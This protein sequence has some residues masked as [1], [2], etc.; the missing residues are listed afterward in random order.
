MLSTLLVTL[1]IFFLGSEALAWT[2]YK[3]AGTK[4]LAT[5]QAS[6][7]S[8]DIPFSQSLDN[9]NEFYRVVNILTDKDPKNNTEIFVQDLSE[10]ENAAAKTCLDLK[11][12]TLKIRPWKNQNN[13]NIGAS[14]LTGARVQPNNG[15]FRLSRLVVDCK[16][17]KGSRVFYAIQMSL[18]F[19][20]SCVEFS[21][22]KLVNLHFRKKE[23]QI[24]E[25][26][27]SKAKI[28]ARQDID[29]QTLAMRIH[30]LV[31]L[32]TIRQAG[33][34]WYASNQYKKIAQKISAQRR[35]KN[36][37]AFEKLRSLEWSEELGQLKQNYQKQASKFPGSYP[38][39]EIR[40][41]QAKNILSRLMPTATRTPSSKQSD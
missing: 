36:E 17:P 5:L 7:V 32:Q 16:A 28:H 21:G 23:E 27:S 19:L 1:C 33:L 41:H 15:S 34:K 26:I 22:Q 29:A 2:G 25:H 4:Y 20:A 14:P 9:P 30:L 18:P 13:S 6:K 35:Q 40:S 12:N 31:G 39:A 3:I 24:S 8:S 38:I 11:N 37:I 10:V